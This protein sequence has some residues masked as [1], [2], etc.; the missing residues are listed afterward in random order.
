MC[1]GQT[2]KGRPMKSVQKKRSSKAMTALDDLF[3]FSDLSYR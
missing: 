3:L 1:I 2:R